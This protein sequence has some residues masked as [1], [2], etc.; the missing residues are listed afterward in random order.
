[1][2]RALGIDLAWGHKATTGVCALDQTNGGWR[3]AEHGSRLSDDEIVAWAASHAA[4]GCVVAIDAPLFIPNATGTRPCD[5]K[6][7]SRYGTY[8]I[9]VHACNRTLFPQPRGELIRQRLEAEHGFHEVSS[10]CEGSLLYFETYPHP[11]IVNVLGLEERIAYKKGRVA[12][13]RAGLSR[14]ACGLWASLPS[15][16]PSVARDAELESLLRRD[17]PQLKGRALKQAE[18]EIDA[19]VCAY[20]AAR[21][22]VLGKSGS[23]VV[24]GPGEGMMIFPS[25]PSGPGCADVRT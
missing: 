25:G 23:E 14:L 24:G 12:K 4:G 18:D 5:R 17:W 16:R 20:A 8:K 7:A 9:G 11:A 15:A 22:I 13:R 19:L 10:G 1:M 2:R 3:V 21:W 6:V